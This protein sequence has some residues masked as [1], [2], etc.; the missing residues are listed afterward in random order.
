MEGCDHLSRSDIA[1][2]DSDGGLLETEGID[3]GS[4]GLREVGSWDRFGNLSRGGSD[5]CC[6]DEK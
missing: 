1:N 3:L 2:A 6:H 4:D 5:H